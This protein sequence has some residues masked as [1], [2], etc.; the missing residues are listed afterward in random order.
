MPARNGAPLAPFSV[1]FG[2]LAAAIG[3]EG[4]ASSDTKRAAATHR[5]IFMRLQ[6]YRR[7]AKMWQ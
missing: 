4:A 3:A 6:G 7:A 5:N 2:A 1:A